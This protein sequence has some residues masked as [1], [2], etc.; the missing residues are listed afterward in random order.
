MAEEVVCGMIEALVSMGYEYDVFFSYKHD[1]QSLDW[2][3]RVKD[4]LGFWLT[5]EMGGIPSRI[6]MDL[7]SLSTGDQWKRRLSHAVRH[8]KCLVAVWSPEYFQSA[9]CLSERKAFQD[10]AQIVGQ[11]NIALV[12]PIRFHDG[13]HFPV[14]AQAVQMADF[15]DHTSIVG[16]GFWRSNKAVELGD[17]I[18]RFAGDV[19]RLVQKAPEFDPTWPAELVEQVPKAPKIGLAQL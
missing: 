5:Q 11:G 10:R 4:Q 3:K 17:L 2:N 18:K 6:F 9:Y 1:G 16:E 13:E 14:E 7:E 19:A 15:R 12:A 8:S